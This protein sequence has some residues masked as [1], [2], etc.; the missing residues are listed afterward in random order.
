MSP[1]WS[2]IAPVIGEYACRI[3][4][5]RL[6]GGSKLFQK[7]SRPVFSA[8]GSEFSFHPVSSLL[9]EAQ[10]NFRPHLLF[11]NCCS[12]S[13]S[14]APLLSI[15]SFVFA[16]QFTDLFHRNPSHYITDPSP[17]M[18]PLQ[19]V[20]LFGLEVPPGDILVPVSQSFPATVSLYLFMPA[21][22]NGSTSQATS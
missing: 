13:Y 11:S 6:I 4:A 14:C 22:C 10:A 9:V 20:A 8:Q 3:T 18:S 5:Y 12:A 21:I 15:Q 7:I 1:P 2:T 17:I 16:T 19:P